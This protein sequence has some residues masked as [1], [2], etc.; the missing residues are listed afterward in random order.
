MSKRLKKA[1]KSEL[2]DDLRAEYDLTKLKGAVRGKYA[3]RFN[4]GTNLVL[5]APDVVEYFPNEE[6]VN[7]ALRSLIRIIKTRRPAD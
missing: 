2:H 1:A 6:S 4:A 7:S 5:L 3:G